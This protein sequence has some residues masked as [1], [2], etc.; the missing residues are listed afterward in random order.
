MLLDRIKSSSTCEVTKKDFFVTL[1]AIIESESA[2]NHNTYFS[3]LSPEQLQ[4]SDA[5]GQNKK[6][7]N[8]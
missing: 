5:T 8:L 6:F 7:F 4:T 1:N 3:F 2:L